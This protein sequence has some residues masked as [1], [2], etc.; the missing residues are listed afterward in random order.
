MAI[1]PRARGSPITGSAPGWMRNRVSISGVSYKLGAYAP[2]VRAILKN[3]LDQMRRSV[4]KLDEMDV[5]L[6]TGGGARLLHSVLAV[7][8]AIVRILLAIRWLHLA[9]ARRSNG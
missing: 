4:G 2:T 6:F 5:I 1:P 7:R 8:P 9:H 3:A